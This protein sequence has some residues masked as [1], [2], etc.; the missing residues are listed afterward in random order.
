[1]NSLNS[2]N[3]VNTMNSVNETPKECSCAH[4]VHA[5]H[6]SHARRPFPPRQ[7]GARHNHT[8]ARSSQTCNIIPKVS[9]H[10]MNGG[11]EPSKMAIPAATSA[12]CLNA[13]L[14]RGQERR[15]SVQPCPMA[16]A[17]FTAG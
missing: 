13:V 12:T 1:M 16:V 4:S 6:D 7:R 3:S 15:A 11:G 9:I 14:K 8:A 2:M 5:V 10:P 17:A